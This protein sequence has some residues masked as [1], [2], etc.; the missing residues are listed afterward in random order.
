MKEVLCDIA[1]MDHCHIL[2]G[3]SWLHFKTFN[4]DEH[5]LY[6][7]HERHKTKLNFVTPRQVSKHRLK[8]KI[9]KK[10]HNEEKEK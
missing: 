5:L 4:L 10:R 1:P 7:R 6:L 3:W 9:E 2:L 8:E